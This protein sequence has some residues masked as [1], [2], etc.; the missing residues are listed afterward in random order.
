MGN[1]KRVLIHV[2]GIDLGSYSAT[3]KAGL[4]LYVGA[5]SSFKKYPY[6]F[7][8]GERNHIDRTWEYHYKVDN[9]ASFVIALYKQHFLGDKE[10]GELELKIS[11]FQPNTVIT[12]RFELQ[13]PNIAAV[14]ARIELEIHLNTDGSQPFQ[15]PKGFLFDNPTILHRNFYDSPE[16][17]LN[18]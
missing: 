10:I 13:S 2:R 6:P 18:N 8:C 16:L 17:K 7:K 3:D 14:P 5:P 1:N 11:A 4:V 9:N 12:E 15:A